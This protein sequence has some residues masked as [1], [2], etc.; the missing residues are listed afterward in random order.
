MDFI[1]PENIAMPQEYRET[2]YNTKAGKDQNTLDYLKKHEPNFTNSQLQGLMP[3]EQAQG[4]MDLATKPRKEISL[5]PL[6]AYRGGKFPDTERLHAPFNE[7][8]SK[9]DLPTGVLFPLMMAESER[10]I[11]KGDSPP[12]SGKGAEGPFQLM[13]EYFPN[14]NRDDI[15]ESAMA[16][17]LELKRDLRNFDGDIDK[18]LASYN[19]GY[20]KFK[21]GFGFDRDKAIKEQKR[22]SRKEYPKDHKNYNTSETEKHSKRFHKY[23]DPSL[24]DR[25]KHFFKDY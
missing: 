16:A 8:E 6:I 11:L 24:L 18:A 15:L 2:L 3:Q 5:K 7:I 12:K 14:V 9:L 22:L 20:G 23:Y 13:P 25:A 1:P 10:W 19:M 4:L 21:R 17:G